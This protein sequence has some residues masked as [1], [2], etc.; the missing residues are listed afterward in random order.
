MDVGAQGDEWPLQQS[1]AGVRGC[2]HNGTFMGLLLQR[3]GRVNVPDVIVAVKV[4]DGHRERQQGHQAPPAAHR[5]MDAITI[6]LEIGDEPVE[7]IERAIGM[8]VIADIID[9]RPIQFQ[10]AGVEVKRIPG[11]WIAL[12]AELAA[13]SQQGTIQARRRGCPGMHHEDFADGI[14]P[15]Q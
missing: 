5:K 14:A 6:S 10:Q 1:D 7:G 9:G 12:A 15:R 11:A 8:C 3:L 2:M 4:E 13:E